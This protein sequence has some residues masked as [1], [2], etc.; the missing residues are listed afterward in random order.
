VDKIIVLH[1][2][3]FTFLILRNAYIYDV[4]RSSSG[5]TKK[6]FYSVPFSSLMVLVRLG[7][8]IRIQ[9]SRIKSASGRH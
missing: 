4:G 7:A 8:P 9:S 5:R 2:L 1:I 6:H 3:I